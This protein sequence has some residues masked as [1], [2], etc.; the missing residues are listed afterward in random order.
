MADRSVIGVPRDR[1]RFSL[2]SGTSLTDGSTMLRVVAVHRNPN[3]ELAA[4]IETESGTTTMPWAEVCQRALTASPMDQPESEL[5][6]APDSPDW[7][8][9][10]ARERRRVLQRARHL[11]Q[12]DTG[13]PDG[14]PDRAARI[15]TLDPRFDPETTTRRQRIRLKA[16]ELQGLG[17]RGVA[18]PTLYRQ[19]HTLKTRGLEGLVDG[20]SRPRQEQGADPNEDVSEALS[21]FLTAQRPKAKISLTKLVVKAQAHL[22]E[23]GLGDRLSAY[24]L[25]NAVGELSRGMGLHHVAK[26]RE[27]HANKPAKVYGRLQ[28]SRPGEIVQVD[29]TDTVVH[30]WDPDLGWV[31]A[32]IL[33]AI[34]VFTRCV[35][36]LRVCS[37]AV[38]A[39]DVAM[40]LWD[41]SRPAVTRSG[42]PYDLGRWHGMPVLLSINGEPLGMDE[43]PGELDEIGIKPA[44]I[45]SM[46]VFDHGS[47]NDSLSIAGICGRA[48]IDVLFC[49]PRSPHAKGIVESYHNFLRES[50]SLLEGY[51]GEN[52]LNHPR[53][54]EAQAFLTPQDLRDYL[55]EAIIGVYHQ[56]RHDGL[57]D[58][59]NPVLR[60][61]PAMKFDQYMATGGY[62]EA[63][64]DP[65][66]LITFLDS[67]NATLNDYGLRVN[68]RTYTS[69]ELVSLRPLLQRGAG[70]KAKPVVVY[71]DRFDVTR[72]Y[73]RHPSTHEWLCVPQA[74][75]GGGAVAPFSELVT[76]VAR[77]MYVSGQQRPLTDDETHQAEVRLLARW[78]SGALTDRRE[79]RLRAVEQSRQR[80]LAHDWADA[81]DEL[82]RMAFP[83][84]YRLDT[85]SEPPPAEKA[86]PDLDEDIEL[87]QTTEALAG[88]A[89]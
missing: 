7:L 78:N 27:A 10:P 37:V 71:F 14:D 43:P 34:C 2:G 36:A 3:G 73:L 83:D 85:A 46:V 30:V 75:P 29:A 55:W 77:R 31:K 50:Q 68:R 57:T 58:P 23:V 44:P 21:D 87:E 13:S 19:L 33:S 39:R 1:G 63:P 53:D 60:F 82:R 41:I 8:A 89:L 79:M 65:Y 35:V 74:T 22:E 61:S 40:L 17:E 51:K 52:P 49:P 54:A 38:T 81:G 18:E 86:D 12:V 67:R 66:R 20:H 6:T 64:R 62:V 24:A 4:T 11:L 9:L 32:V 25:R 16:E 42:H 88:Y 80:Q 5:L 28:A 48:G 56:R 76:D 26:S 15:G 70:T 59:N 72:I 45:P 69:D 84:A 47:E